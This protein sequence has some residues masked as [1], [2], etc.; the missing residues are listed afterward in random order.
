MDGGPGSTPC[1]NQSLTHISPSQFLEQQNV[2]FLF[3]LAPTLCYTIIL[4][5]CGVL[6]NTLVFLVYYHRFKPGVTRTY[7]LAM[8]VCDLM[9]NV[10]SLPADIVEVRFHNTFDQRW[11]CKAF[12][13]GKSFL[14]FLSA[15]LLVAVALDRHRTIC[16]PRATPPRVTNVYVIVA[17]SAALSLA[18][19]LP[20]TVLTGR[21][22]L[23]FP[24]TNLTGSRCSI[25]DV[26]A[27][28]L[29][30][31]AYNVVTGVVFLV[32]M[33]LMVLSY[34]RIARQLWLHKTRT[35]VTGTA[36]GLRR[37][38]SSVH[39]THTYID[40]ETCVGLP[41]LSASA[42]PHRDEE[43]CT[44]DSASPHHDEE[45]CT[46]DSACPHH[47]EETCL[48]LP[49]L[50]ASASPHHDEETCTDDSASPHHDEETCTDD[51]AY[52]HHD[53]TPTSKSCT[54]VPPAD[55]P[56]ECFSEPAAN[57]AAGDLCSGLSSL[58]QVSH[59]T[60][61]PSTALMTENAKCLESPAVALTEMTHSPSDSHPGYNDTGTSD[62]KQS[63][64]TS[65]SREVL[66]RIRRTASDARSFLTRHKP[67]Q[68]ARGSVKKIPT[69]TT[70]MMFVLTVVFIVNYLPYL[71]LVSLRSRL[72]MEVLVAGLGLNGY[73]IALRSYFI[74]SAVNPLVYSFCSARFRQEC[75]RLCGCKR[76]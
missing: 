70:L 66:S 44:D 61:M 4:M 69:R 73:H 23:H 14:S 30:L 57:S 68:K 36:P 2:Q 15:S 49:H 13:T 10:L 21:R 75:R 11:L 16:R 7:I 19:T 72:G 1:P 32:C 54:A 17:V 45:T 48:D 29:F 71:L 35:R 3:S 12:R 31:F 25:D 5:A 46:D 50:S 53:T 6:G 27:G 64:P 39:K 43:T 76:C 51:S 37:T 38:G 55:C 59:Q 42:S 52:P 40:E 24:H 74:N 63:G 9:T 34:V 58:C 26:Y 28:S 33:V 8:S 65:R 60:S 56:S 22:S 41:Q 62:L 18:V 47:D 67:T 20:Y